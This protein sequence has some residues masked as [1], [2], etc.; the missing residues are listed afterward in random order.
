[1]TSVS[2][3]ISS[4]TDTHAHICDAS[5]VQDLASVLERAERSGVGSILAVGEDTAVVW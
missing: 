2:T 4:L 5:F 1:M 3:L